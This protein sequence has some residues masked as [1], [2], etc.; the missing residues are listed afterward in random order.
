MKRT[1]TAAIAAATA[2]SLAVVPAYAEDAKDPGK[3]DTNASSN[4][5]QGSSSE[6]D[7]QDGKKVSS[8]DIT[9]EQA[10]QYWKDNKDKATGLAKPKE[11]QDEASSALLS[12]IKSD[13]SNGWEP[14]KTANILLGTGIGALVL[15]ILAVVAGG[16][17]LPGL[18][19]IKL[20][21]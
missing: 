20:P 4:D 6:G 14:G 19:N 11:G 8:S 12:S 18:G 17:A 15:G 2:L 16:G 10:Q 3:D 5:N 7:Q 1:A 9:D 21:F 13:A